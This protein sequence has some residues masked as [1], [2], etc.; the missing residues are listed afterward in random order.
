MF[1]FVMFIFSDFYINSISGD[2]WLLVCDD[3]FDW[4]CFEGL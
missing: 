4:E 1:N 3:W 2:D